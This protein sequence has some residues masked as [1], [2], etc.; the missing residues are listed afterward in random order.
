MAA[1]VGCGG[2]IGEL[3][4]RAR[5]QGHR[6]LGQAADHQKSAEQAAENIGR[7]LRDQFLIWV[8]VTP[9][10]DRR[11]LCRTERLRIADQHDGERPGSELLQYRHVEAGQDQVRQPRRNV[12]GDMNAGRLCAEQADGG[13]GDDHHNQCRGDAGCEISEQLH[14]SEAEQ[15]GQDRRERGIRQ[16]PEHI[17]GFGEEVARHTLDAKQVRHLAHDGDIDKP[18]DEAAHH[19]RGNKGGHPTHAHD[20]E[21]QKEQTDQDGQGRGQHVV[22]RRALNCDRSHGERGDQAGGGVRSDNKLT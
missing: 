10:L 13:G 15:P 21:Q 11:G 17:P 9:A 5:G 8:N 1:S 14:R 3:T 19:R 7:P 16:M 20:T 18:F 4:A 22:F 12:P 2:E 6:G